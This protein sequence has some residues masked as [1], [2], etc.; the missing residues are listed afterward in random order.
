VKA[1]GRVD[2]ATLVEQPREPTGTTLLRGQP[3]KPVVRRQRVGDD[4]LGDEPVVDLP[5]RH[6]GV[7]PVEAVGDDG[8]GPLDDAGPVETPAVAHNVHQTKAATTPAQIASVMM[9][10]SSS[11]TSARIM[12]P[13]LVR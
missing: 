4:V 2:A 10:I 1:D 11:R 12:S 9:K 3:P 13:R 8:R 6:H 7:V 5:E